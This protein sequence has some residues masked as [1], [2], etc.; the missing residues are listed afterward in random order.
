MEQFNL[1]FN[2]LRD[3]GVPVYKHLDDDGNFSISESSEWAS[4]FGGSRDWMFGVHPD[5]DATLRKY[6]LYAEWVNPERLAVYKI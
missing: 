1:A 6:G 4:Y 5:V 2:A 3:M